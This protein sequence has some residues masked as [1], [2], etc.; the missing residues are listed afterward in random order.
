[1]GW[2]YGEGGKPVETPDRP[3]SGSGGNPAPGPNQAWGNASMPPPG[4]KWENG[5]LVPTDSTKA[6]WAADQT[7]RTTDAS[8]LNRNTGMREIDW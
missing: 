1:M 5:Q 7:Q 8:L 3:F 6:G 2:Y 4:Y